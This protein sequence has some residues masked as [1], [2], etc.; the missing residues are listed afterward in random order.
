MAKK[1]FR[2]NLD[3]ELVKELKKRAKKDYLTVEELINQILWRSAKRSMKTTSRPKNASEFVRIFS[4]YKPYHDKE[5]YCQLC[6]IHHRYSSKIGK[7]HF[8]YKKNKNGS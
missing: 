6:K 4:R 2:V 8:K 1:S 7:Q 3:E 5:Y